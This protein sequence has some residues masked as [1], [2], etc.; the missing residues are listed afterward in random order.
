MRN[1]LVA[2]DA[3]IRTF[4]TGDTYSNISGKHNYVTWRHSET[5]VS[6]PVSAQLLL[7]AVE[8]SG[9]GVSHSRHSFQPTLIIYIANKSH[10]HFRMKG[11]Y[12]MGGGV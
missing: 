6:I 2:I 12:K 7:L 8:N 5:V 3:D 11:M 4:R 10:F 9:E 1:S